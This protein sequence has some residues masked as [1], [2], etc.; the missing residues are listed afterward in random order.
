MLNF[1]DFRNPEN[2]LA[3]FVFWKYVM[4]YRVSGDCVLVF[5]VDRQSD[6]LTD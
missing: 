5:Q 2:P 6:Q 4:E 3:L 1:R